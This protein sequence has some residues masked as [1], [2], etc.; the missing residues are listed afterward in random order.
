MN[1]YN[2]LLK[3][4]LNVTTSIITVFQLWNDNNQLLITYINFDM[5]LF[6]QNGNPWNTYWY[7]FGMFYSMAH[8][9]TTMVTNVSITF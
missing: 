6:V 7:M 5:K 9:E 1:E 8:K 2:F 3:L 4:T